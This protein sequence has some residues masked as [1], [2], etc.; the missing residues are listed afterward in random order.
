MDQ[1]QIELEI[2]KLREHILTG[3]DVPTAK[4]LPFKQQYGII[5]KQM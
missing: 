2:I 1:K 5:V 3:E 4:E